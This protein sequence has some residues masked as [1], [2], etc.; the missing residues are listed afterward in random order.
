VRSID[1][2]HD[3]P[4]GSTTAYNEGEF[5]S[6]RGTYST[7]DHPAGTGVITGVKEAPYSGPIVGNRGRLMPS[8]NRGGLMPSGN[9][10]GSAFECVR[11]A[12]SSKSPLLQ[13]HLLKHGLTDL[14]Q[15]V[16]TNNKTI[17]SRTQVKKLESSGT[18]LDDIIKTSKE[19]SDKRQKDYEQQIESYQRQV[20]EVIS[21][22]KQNQRYMR[23]ETKRLL[24]EK[25]HV[26]IQAEKIV[27]R[28]STQSPNITT[29]GD[30]KK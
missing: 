16:V 22:N 25:H 1:R 8:G 27:N 26:A 17:I 24:E 6:E 21:D 11:F 2:S 7:G 3:I 14:H 5:T 23:K 9:T 12:T 20:N 29:T 4:H 15:S 13:H 30:G 19:L 28:Y 10:K 18:T